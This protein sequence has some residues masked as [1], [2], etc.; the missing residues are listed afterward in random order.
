MD[1]IICAQNIIHVIGDAA[2]II[3][4][5]KKRNLCSKGKYRNNILTFHSDLDLLYV[6]LKFLL[7]FLKGLICWSLC[8]F[9]W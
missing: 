4:K 2:K 6:F 1:W 9:I 5:S 3:N 8:H 7:L